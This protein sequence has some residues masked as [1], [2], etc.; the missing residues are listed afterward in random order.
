MSTQFMTQRIAGG[1]GVYLV[2]AAAEHN[3]LRAPM[4]IAASLALAAWGV[5][6]ANRARIV[7]AFE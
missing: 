6:F 1:V 2:G 4:L 5:A 3:G 7:A